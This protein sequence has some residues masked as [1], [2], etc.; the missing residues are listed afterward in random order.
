MLVFNESVNQMK[1]DI[2]AEMVEEDRAEKAKRLMKFNQD[3][4]EQQLS[5]IITSFLSVPS[6]GD[7]NNL[8]QFDSVDLEWEKSERDSERKSTASME[9]VFLRESMRLKRNSLLKSQG[10][11]SPS[12]EAV[13]GPNPITKLY[14]R[15]SIVS[16]SSASINDLQSLGSPSAI[17]RTLN[18]Q[19]DDDE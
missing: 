4:A 14:N 18:G 3:Y 12:N 9:R 17:D 1:S 7:N 13:D 6:S 5:R 15:L 16:E 11:A 19:E 8:R 2:Q 10:E